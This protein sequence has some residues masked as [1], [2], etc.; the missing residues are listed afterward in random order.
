[1]RWKLALLLLSVLAFAPCLFAQKTTG[2]I[3]GTVTDNS[4]AVVADAS[5]TVT[6]AQTGAT[7]TSQTN[8]EGSFF[9]P[10][11][12]PGVYSIMVTKPGFKKVE[13]KNIALHVSDITNIPI[14]L[15]VG[16]LM[17]TVVVEATA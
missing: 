12:N 8:S 1:M 17:E 9:F 5:V 10:E 6:S 4:G 13:E 16:G 7:R 15:P 11:L 3:S 14:K 2:T